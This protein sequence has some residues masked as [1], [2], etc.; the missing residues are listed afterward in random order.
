MVELLECNFCGG[1]IP[2]DRTI[3][4]I[5]LKHS[6]M[7]N[8]GYK[9]YTGSVHFLK[10]NACN[11]SIPAVEMEKQYHKKRC[12]KDASV[13][14]F[15]ENEIFI[16]EWIKCGICRRYYITR[17]MSLHYQDEH[18]DRM[19][20]NGVPNFEFVNRSN[21]LNQDTPVQ[22]IPSQQLVSKH[23][24]NE[25]NKQ[26]PISTQKNIAELEEP[27]FVKCEYCGR[28]LPPNF[29]DDHIQQEH[30]TD[31]EDNDKDDNDDSTSLS[32]HN[33]G[34]SRSHDPNPKTN[35]TLDNDIAPIVARVKCERCS[36]KIRLHKIEKH[37][38]RKHSKETKTKKKLNRKINEISSVEIRPANKDRKVS[39]SVSLNGDE[40]KNQGEVKEESYTIYVSKNEL[41]KFL[42]AKRIYPKNGMFYLKDSQN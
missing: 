4:H 16:D 23:K 2:F 32:S 29:I 18:K 13:S 5:R 20:K 39:E 30:V 11:Y 36:K 10:C 21:V 33:N 19:D 3:I 40:H 6:K 24:P 35:Q 37:I 28:D 26:K 22:Q 27:I 8:Y 17:D 7:K 14:M 38:R 15:N 31:I 41:E 34:N 12:H 42:L 25:S 1:I 9:R